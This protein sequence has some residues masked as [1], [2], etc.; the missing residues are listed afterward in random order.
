MKRYLLF[1]LLSVFFVCSSQGQR[2]K[3]M[4]YEAIVGLGT[5]NIFGDIG[6]TP[7]DGNLFG[8]KDFKLNETR[9]SAFLGIRYKLF[10]DQAIRLN[11]IY[12]MGAGDDAES[13]N[14]DRGYSYST[15]I[16]EPSLQYEYYFIPEERKFRS[17]ALFNRR[18]MI[19]NYSR[20]AAYAFAGV[21][22]VMFMPTFGGT[23]STTAELGENGFAVAF[24]AGIGAKY[25]INSELSIGIEAGGR[26]VL[27]DYLDGVTTQFS[28]A[29]DVYYFGLVNLVYKLRTNRNGVP[30]IFTKK[31]GKRRVS[32]ATRRRRR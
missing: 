6:G 20:L 9:P 5:T 28:N 14:P 13:R 4:R 25:S 31:P 3:L 2:W 15:M 21:G 18:G 17:A 27:S 24:P 23:P 10:Q 12:G 7:D 8:L 22:G 26:Y 1:S 29:N 19:N 16:I 11:I 32:S 30:V